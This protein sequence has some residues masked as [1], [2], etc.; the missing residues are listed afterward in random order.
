[1]SGFARLQSPP[2]QLDR[3]GRIEQPCA[4]DRMQRPAEPPLRERPQSARSAIE[5]VDCPNERL[6]GANRKNRVLSAVGAKGFEPLT[7]PV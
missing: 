4:R 6:L 2:Q 3:A 1:M 5:A 7:S